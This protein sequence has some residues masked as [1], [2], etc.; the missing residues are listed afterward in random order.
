MLQ[1]F[2]LFV[3]IRIPGCLPNEYEYSNYSNYSNYGYSNE[4]FTKLEPN[5]S[6]MDFS[7]FKK[8]WGIFCNSGGNQP[9]EIL[10]DQ[11]FECAEDSLQ[12]TLFANLGDRWDTI[13]SADLLKEVEV[14][15]VEKQSDMLNEVHLMEA[16]QDRNEP[17]R[18]YLARLRGLANICSLTVSC[19]HNPSSAVSYAERSI[20][21]TLVKGL[22][23]TETKGE[24]LSK[25]DM[26]TLA[27]TVTFLEARETGKRSLAGLSGTLAGQSIHVV[28]CKSCGEMG[29][30]A[31]APL[32]IRKKLCSCEEVWQAQPLHQV[33]QAEA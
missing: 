12:K 17:V 7:V 9:D 10:R 22:F 33:L 8:R 23:D 11:L 14:V 32:N 15:A 1:I 29:H 4:N 18:K 27:E 31:D 3:S 2:S 16:K 5:C 26:P 6:Q 25:V 21:T 24:I 13:S 30:S 19:P 28:Q 20:H